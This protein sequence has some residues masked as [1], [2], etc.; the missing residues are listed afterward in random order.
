[1]KENKVV[2]TAPAKAAVS[3]SYKDFDTARD[4]ND[5]LVPYKIIYPG[6]GETGHRLM[7]HSMH[8]DKFRKAELKAKR[9]VSSLFIA[10]SAK[11]EG[12][13]TKGDL[14]ELIE[15]I[16]MRA[17]AVLVESWTFDEP[18][19]PENVAEF[20]I[21]NRFIYDDLNVLAAQ[22]SL[23]LTGTENS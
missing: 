9:Q 19:T 1:M 3:Q 12:D 8:C 4:F 6:M 10:D 16:E 21:R 11:K 17:F 18:C 22:S 2:S 15:D 5:T 7:V 23:F 20:L 13:P 14:D